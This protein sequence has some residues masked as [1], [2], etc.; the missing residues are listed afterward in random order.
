MHIYLKTQNVKMTNVEQA[1]K[2][3]GIH[4][5]PSD[6]LNGSHGKDG[7]AGVTEIFTKH[8]G[9]TETPTVHVVVRCNTN[10]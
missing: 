3:H 5:N 1:L 6:N 2:A 10:I 9:V 7:V 8:T 4:T